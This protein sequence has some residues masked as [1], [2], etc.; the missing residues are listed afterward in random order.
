[1]ATATEL[2]A[3][4]D[5]AILALMTS[6]IAEYQIGEI[7]YRYH[8]LGVLREWRKELK[9]ETRSAG[10]RIRLANMGGA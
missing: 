7:K 1:M 2:L 9:A 5:A 10:S 8:D 4:V 6:K 3:A